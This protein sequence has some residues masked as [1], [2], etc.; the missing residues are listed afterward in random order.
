MS[1]LLTVHIAAGTLSVLSGAG[2]LTFRKGGAAH[3]MAGSVFAGAMTVMAVTAA[4]LGKDVGNVVAGGLTIYMIGTGWMAVRRKENRSGL[5]EI[6]A[7][8]AAALFALASAAGAVA[9][10]TGA[11][12]SE[13]PFIVVASLIISAALAGAAAGDLSVVLRRGLAGPQRIAR[14]LWRMC[15]GLVIA[16][17]SFAAQGADALPPVVPGPA[18]LLGSLGLVLIVMAYWLVRVLFT[19]WRRPSPPTPRPGPGSLEAT[20]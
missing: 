11:R 7:F 10:L 9:R 20:P 5:F 13:N 1:A 14:H 19:N 16:V 4:A 18:L 15:F 2:A 12:E 3:R 17:G 8:L 6:A